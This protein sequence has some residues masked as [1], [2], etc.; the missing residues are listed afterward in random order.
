MFEYLILM[1]CATTDPYYSQYHQPCIS[2][3]T[4]ASIQT[5]LK[6]NVDNLQK[7]YEKQ[8][9]KET[10]EQFWGSILFG[11]SVYSTQKVTIT[12]PIRPFADSMG[13]VIQQSGINTTFTW[14]F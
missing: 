4:A 7:D 13:I 12:T 8:L 5:H 14:N 2:A 6:S 3:L 10:N 11:Y 9:A 1:T